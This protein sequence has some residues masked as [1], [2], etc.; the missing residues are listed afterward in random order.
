MTSPLAW[1]RGLKLFLTSGKK[2]FLLSPLAWGRGLK[3]T[4]IAVSN[5]I[6]CVAPRVGAW[7]E[8]QNA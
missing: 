2:M 5:P 1:G 3:P 4:C 8:T 7:I 6:E